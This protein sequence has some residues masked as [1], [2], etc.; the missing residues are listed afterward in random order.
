MTAYKLR[1]GPTIGFGTD[2]LFAALRRFAAARSRRRD[3]MQLKK[4][5]KDGL[6]PTK[7]AREQ[8]MARSSVYRLLE[9]AER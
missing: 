5:A 9:K 6:G 3:R 8:G 1:D 4:L 7:I 2:H